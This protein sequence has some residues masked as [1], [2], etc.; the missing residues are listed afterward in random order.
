VGK[1]FAEMLKFCGILGKLL[2]ELGNLHA[3]LGNLP[4]ELGNLHAELGNLPPELGN[5][6]AVLGNRRRYVA[7]TSG[8][9]TF[10]P[11]MSLSHW[12]SDFPIKKDS[13][14]SES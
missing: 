13:Q 6:H 12:I 7:F 5:L 10:S 14:L 11:V 1:F 9:R 2:A 4:P 3:E 8:Y